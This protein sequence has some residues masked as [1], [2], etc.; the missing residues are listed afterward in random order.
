MRETASFGGR[1]NKKGPPPIAVL[2]MHDSDSDWKP[3]KNE[4]LTQNTGKFGEFLK[5]LFSIFSDI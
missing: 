2:H 1:F 5:M 4:K 3:R